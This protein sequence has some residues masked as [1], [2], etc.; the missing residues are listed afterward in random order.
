MPK[1]PLINIELVRGPILTVWN[2]IGYDM[3]QACRGERM[4]NSAMVE[5]CIDADRLTFFAYKGKNDPAALA[6][7]AEIDR[8]IKAHGYP[9]VLR[10]LARAIHLT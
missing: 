2:A 8:A 5:A 1:S 10:A 6:A 9:R 7:E 4:T 3:E